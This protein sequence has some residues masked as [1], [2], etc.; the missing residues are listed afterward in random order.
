LKPHLIGLRRGK[1]FGVTLYLGF[2]NDWVHDCSIERVS[3]LPN[4]PAD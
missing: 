4:P 2:I 3:R 1:F